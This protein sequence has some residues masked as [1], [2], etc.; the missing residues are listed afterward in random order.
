MRIAKTRW[1]Q[2]S[3]TIFA[4]RHIRVNRESSKV[5]S[6]VLEEL[7]R[8]LGRVSHCK[9]LLNALVSEHG[10]IYSA[11][12][13]VDEL[14]KTKPEISHAMGD[15]QHRT[16]PIAQRQDTHGGCAYGIP[17]KLS[18]EPFALPSRVARSSCT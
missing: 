17:R 2:A 11:A 15:S 13:G 1:K 6:E 16:I 3:L 18:I 5:R 14:R 4:L 9:C 8:Q 12:V 7:G 10:G